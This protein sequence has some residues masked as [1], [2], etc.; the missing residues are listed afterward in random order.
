MLK[1]SE[2]AVVGKSQ[3]DK[4]K[5]KHK[6]SKGCRHKARARI[7]IRRLKMKIARWK[8]NQK[9]PSKEHTFNKHQKVCRR[10]RYDNWNTSGLEKQLKHHE[11]M[12]KRPALSS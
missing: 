6:A 8:R 3:K 1:L 7:S 11:Q 9:N 5:T 2:G 12:L 10:S 4:T